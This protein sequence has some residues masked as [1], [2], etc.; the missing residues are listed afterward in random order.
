MSESLTSNP[1]NSPDRPE[2][3]LHDQRGWLSITLSCIGD[4]VITADPNGRVTYLNPVDE[5]LTGWTLADA[6][7]K[8]I[9]QVFP[10]FNEETH[11]PIAQPVRKVIEQGVTVGLG[12]HTLL[13]AKDGSERPIDDSAAAIKDDQGAVIGVVLIFRDITERRNAER[14]IDEAR[15]YAESIVTTVREPLLILDARL[16]VRSANRSFYKTFKVSPAETEGRFIYD[17]G[18]GQ[19]NISALKGLL[20]E[21]LPLQSSFDHFE[22]EHVFEQVGPKT[23]LLNA[24][25]LSPGRPS[26]ADPSSR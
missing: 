17:L 16:C 23:M 11:T 8:E 5:K 20:E 9:E 13:I 14:R 25:L 6:V 21:L 18:D 4:G 19:W 22:V 7:G 10:I 24:T 12:N 2:R 26:R 1:N 15:V 3:A